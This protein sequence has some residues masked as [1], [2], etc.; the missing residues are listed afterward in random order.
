[1]MAKT[2]TLRLND[3]QSSLIDKLLSQYGSPNTASKLLLGMLSDYLP[4]QA[5]IDELERN[6]G[7][8]ERRVALLQGILSDAENACKAVIDRTSQTDIFED[9]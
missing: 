1:M 3:S 4:T 9:G 5:T 7:D 6:N 2:L 8:L